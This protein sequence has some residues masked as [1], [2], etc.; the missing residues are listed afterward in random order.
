[1]LVLGIGSALREISGD[2]SRF[3]MTFVREARTAPRYRLY[4]L[5][6]RF[7]ALVEDE[8]GGISVPG[9]L[10][11]VPDERWAEIAATEPPGITPGPVELDDGTVVTAALGDPAYL[12]EHGVDITEHGGFAAYRRSL[13]S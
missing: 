6:E 13:E 8:E 11:E 2:Q 9:E 5:E 3:G 10:V 12:R 4:S 7:A 1:M